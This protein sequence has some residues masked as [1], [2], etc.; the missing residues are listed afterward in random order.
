MPLFDLEDPQTGD[1]ITVDHPQEPTQ[2]EA[3]AIFQQNT[4][5]PPPEQA[6]TP[7]VVSQ[8]QKSVEEFIKSQQASPLSKVGDM[9]GKT[10]NALIAEPAKA[11]IKLPFSLSA[12]LASE[13]PN[14]PIPY[15]GGTLNNAQSLLEGGN[16]LAYNIGTGITDL[17]RKGARNAEQKN[18]IE[19]ALRTMS[20]IG[21]GI[22]DLRSRTPTAQE[23]ENF[24]KD[25]AIASGTQLGEDELLAPEVLGKTNLQMAKDIESASNLLPVA[26]QA[27]TVAKLIRSPIK[28]VK[29]LG[30]GLEDQLRGITPVDPEAVAAAQK[31]VQDLEYLREQN[32]INKT[33]TAEARNAQDLILQEELAAAKAEADSLG[34]EA[35]KANQELGPEIDRLNK[36]AQEAPTQAE[37]VR[38]KLPK[39]E[40]PS[41]LKKTVQGGID[42]TLKKEK[43]LEDAD[44]KEVRES[45]PE[46]QPKVQGANQEA[47]A[48]EILAEKGA[49][50]SVDFRRDLKS[51][52]G[53]SLPTKDV[54]PLSRLSPQARDIYENLP[55]GQRQNFLDQA[56]ISLEKKVPKSYTW[57]ELEQR[58]KGLNAEIR[59]AQK[60]RPSEVRPLMKLKEA[61]AKDMEEYA[62]SVGTST[63]S[64]FDQANSRFAANRAAREGIPDLALSTPET[65][66]N[67]IVGPNK[68]EVVNGLKKVLDPEKFNQ[69]KS[70]Y[71]DRLM[72]PTKDV[73]F[74]PEHFVKQFDNMSDETLTAVFGEEGFAQLKKIDELSKAANQ[75]KGLQSRLDDFNKKAQKSV[76]DYQKA[77]SAADQKSILDRARAEA[78]EALDAIKDEKFQRDIEKARA[79]LK[80][81]QTPEKVRLI[82]RSLYGLLSAAG[83]LLTGGSGAAALAAGAAATAF[84]KMIH[85]SVGTR[86]IEALARPPK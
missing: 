72:S 71:A 10:F 74:D 14:I 76:D 25:Q 78:D 49:G 36:A 3:L 38:S 12:G 80:L 45:L 7:P 67:N 13:N 86:V 51:R 82:T 53:E 70:Q 58:Y 28:T 79:D 43:V 52:V 33:K 42:D 19:T 22:L 18:P 57:D 35:M 66:V 21:A 37:G 68:V 77:K 56:G 9:A 15:V 24:K 2:E 55:E 65:I 83:V 75:A 62:S 17:V 64:L 50:Y 30:K 1:I 39:P 34:A 5:P 29:R 26:G 23:I 60:N 73:P 44:Y 32:L 84:G 40:Q 20:P 81:A 69:V 59:E 63:K 11:L 85:K 8:E 54:D 16:R 61:V 31:K 6:S 41:Q 46:S 27:G 4:T 47:A 48:Q